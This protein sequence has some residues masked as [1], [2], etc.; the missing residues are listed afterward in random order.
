MCKCQVV[1]DD[2]KDVS[3]ACDDSGH[4][5]HDR[6]DDD[7]S[8]NS[9]SDRDAGKSKGKSTDDDE[10][11]SGTQSKGIDD[12]DDKNGGPDVLTMAWK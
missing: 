1:D 5:D 6:N 11:E 12:N 9:K 3:K 8:E 7:D 2:G 4:H 10:H